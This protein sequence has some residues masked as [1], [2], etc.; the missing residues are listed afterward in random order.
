MSDK[1][2]LA[3]PRVEPTSVMFWYSK[4]LH[5]LCVGHLRGLAWVILGAHLM[6]LPEFKVFTVI[7][8]LKTSIFAHGG[9]VER[10]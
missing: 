8:H 4:G 7:L 1:G 6:D 3:L 5:C 10:V 9:A 2:G